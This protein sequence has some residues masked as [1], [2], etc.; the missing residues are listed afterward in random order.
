MDSDEKQQPLALLL[1]GLKVQ[2]LAQGIN[3]PLSVTA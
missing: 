1:V 2:A 3:N